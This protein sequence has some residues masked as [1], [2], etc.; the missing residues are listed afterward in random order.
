L[1][2][3]ISGQKLGLAE[4]EDCRCSS[5]FL[6]REGRIFPNLSTANCA[7]VEPSGFVPGVGRDGCVWRF[8][9]GDV[10]GPDC[11][12]RT[13]CRVLCVRIKDLVVILIFFEILFVKVYP[14]PN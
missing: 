1:T 12:F 10:L 5:F 7:S 3:A 13:F 6:L 14:P 2:T 8:A 11:V 4:L 9:G